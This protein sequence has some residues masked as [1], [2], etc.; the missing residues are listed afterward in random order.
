[1]SVLEHWFVAWQPSGLTVTSLPSTFERIRGL[2]DSMYIIRD[3]H[4]D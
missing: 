4:D 3:W 1:M 2:Q